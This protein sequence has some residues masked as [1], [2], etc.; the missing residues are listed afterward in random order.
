M[1]LTA[2]NDG[3]V[4]N[5]QR[6]FMKSLRK[7]GL[8]KD[9]YEK[10][11]QLRQTGHTSDDA[12]TIAAQEFGWNDQFSDAPTTEEILPGVTAA[13]IGAAAK[14]LKSLPHSTAFDWLP[15]PLLWCF[16]HI[17]EP[18]RT[19]RGC[20][21]RETWTLFLHLAESPARTAAFLDKVIQTMMSMCTRNRTI[22][23]AEDEEETDE[24]GLQAIIGRYMPQTKRE[25]SNGGN[26]MRVE[27]RVE[28]EAP[29]TDDG[30]R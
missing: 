25:G 1:T 8:K 27:G 26:Q 17:H 12:W 15:V 18:P 30:D 29:S 21:D 14:K 7:R 5:R 22:E 23:G 20:P 19:V 24:T 3:V 10:A 11:R 2:D 16:Q 4:E 13:Q 9:F 28:G 6:L